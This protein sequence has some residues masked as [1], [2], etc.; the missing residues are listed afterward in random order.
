[1]AGGV[2][3]GGSEWLPLSAMHG[4]YGPLGVYSPPGWDGRRWVCGQLF[5]PHTALRGFM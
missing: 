1:M 2:G 3:R 5:P 4:S